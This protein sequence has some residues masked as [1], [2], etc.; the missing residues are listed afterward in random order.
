MHAIGKFL[1]IGLGAASFLIVPLANA[2]DRS[3][4]QNQSPPPLSS[5]PSTT[6][7]GMPPARQ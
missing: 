7:P 3:P 4:A 2:Q 1:A 5:T 6:T